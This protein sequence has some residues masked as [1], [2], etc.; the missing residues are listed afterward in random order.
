MGWSAYPSRNKSVAKLVPVPPL[1]I[2][3]S[4]LSR[5]VPAPSHL[6]KRLV[7]GHAVTQLAV[8]RPPNRV[9]FQPTLAGCVFGHEVADLAKTASSMRFGST[10][11]IRSAAL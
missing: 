11:R 1:E 3:L 9:V 4:R 6:S 2:V 7:F 5:L 10:A 8:Q